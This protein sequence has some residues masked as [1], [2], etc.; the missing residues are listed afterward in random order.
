MHAV[1]G[2]RRLK[3]NSDVEK[4]HA[5]LL[6]ARASQENCLDPNLVSDDSDGSDNQG[7]LAQIDVRRNRKSSI[8]VLDLP[9]SFNDLPFS[10]STAL[11]RDSF[12][13]AVPERKKGK[14]K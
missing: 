11:V 8:A 2:L 7:D 1:A 3:A 13:A 14:Q 4:R 12:L 9:F 10:T 6:L 5:D